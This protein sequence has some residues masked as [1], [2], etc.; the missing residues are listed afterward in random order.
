MSDD[1][2]EVRDQR[3]RDERHAAEVI[4]SI[5]AGRHVACGTDNALMTR[6]LTRTSAEEA[7]RLA[8]ERQGQRWAAYPC[9]WCLT[10]H[11]G[12]APSEV[13]RATWAQ[14]ARLARNA[15]FMLDDR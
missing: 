7:A 1:R 14:V 5:A 11:V 2:A 10:Y 8:S 4:A 13:E 3:R 15:W 9:G 12:L 6:H